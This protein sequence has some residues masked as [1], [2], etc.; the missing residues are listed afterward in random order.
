M[1]KRLALVAASVAALTVLAACGSSGGGG[2]NTGAATG[3][4]TPAGAGGSS[5]AGGGGGNTAGA[6]LT[7]ITVGVVPYS[8]DAIHWY[9]IDGG[10][11][12]K[13]GLNV[14]TEA[15]ASP[16]AIAA[17]M[18]SGKQQFGFT[19]TPVLVNANISG[20]GQKCV[21][22]VAGQSSPKD[23]TALVVP[24]GS[25]IKS[26]KDLKGKTIA[27]VQLGSLNRL[28]M[29]VLLKKAGV[30]NNDVKHV[31]IP[32]PQMPQA[33]ASGRVDAAVIVD[34]FLQTATKA[35][36]KVIVQPNAELYAGGTIVCFAATTKYLDGHAKVAGEF[37][38]AMNESLA[39]FKTHPKEVLKTLVKYLKLSPEAAA[40]QKIETNY[41]PE[42]NVK[43]IGM[44]QQQM[45]EFGWIK[46]TVDPNTMVW[47]PGN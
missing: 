16:I 9:G 20:A 15:A 5:A 8:P 39:Y 19:T 35:G 22:S 36:G 46:K 43:S 26:L 18:A 3:G 27:E 25:D 10:I 45:K 4:S 41:N 12:K 11:Y 38:A 42:L 32:F 13:H 37:Q 31:A 17:A 33:L 6:G 1:K 47:S 34:P 40:N 28:A 29:Q 30:D 2:E 14:K 21:T 24:K 44:I 7:D 23:S